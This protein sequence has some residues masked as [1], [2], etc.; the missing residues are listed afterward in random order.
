M[1]KTKIYH[2]QA[3]LNLGEVSEV[4]EE[5]D[6][7]E[8]S[9]HLLNYALGRSHTQTF[10]K[11]SYNNIK[12]ICKVGI[13]IKAPKP[14]P[15]L[16]MPPV[17][18]QEYLDTLMSSGYEDKSDIIMPFLSPKPLKKGPFTW[19]SDETKDNTLRSNAE[20]H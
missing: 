20:S 7:D 14:E 3:T 10:K 12:E 18:E 2:T 16:K 19:N 9:S 4:L 13:K 1:D 5:D 11:P 15:K 17:A 6:Y 8:G